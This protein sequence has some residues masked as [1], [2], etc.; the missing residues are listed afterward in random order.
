MSFEIA[1][2]FV[3]VVPKIDSGE[4]DAATKQVEGDFGGTADNI[5]KKGGKLGGALTKGV[6]APIVGV[7]GALGGMAMSAADSADGIAKA[8][9][10]AGVST[11]SYQEL[12]YALG[13]AGVEQGTFDRLLQRNNQ[14]LGR[15]AEGNEKYASAYEDLGI[16]ITDSNGEL[17]SSEDVF[18][19]VMTALAGIEDPAIR[20]AKA[21]ELLG[22]KSG[23]ELA[24][25]LDGGIDGINGARDA[26]HDLGIVMDKDAMGAA[27]GF[28]DSID[29]LK[30]AFGGIVA[31]IGSAALPMLESLM[32]VIQE[33]LVPAIRSFAEMVGGLVEKFVNASP[34]M[35]GFIAGAIGIAAAAG[36][37]I[38][39][40]SKVIGVFGKL[41]KAFAVVKKAF[42][43]MKVLMLAN[44]FV[45]IVAA[46]VALVVLIVMN[47]DTIKEYLAAAWEWIKTTAE[48]V[49]N[50]ISEF[51]TN[52]WNGLVEFFVSIWEGIKEFFTEAW[53]G[54]KALATTVWDGIKTYFET[55]FN[56]YKTIIE[57]A[58][59]AITQFLSNIWT[60]IK[61]KAESIWNAVK[62]FFTTVF[63]AYRTIIENAWN[64]I[65]DFLSGLWNGIKNTAAT[66]FNAVKD[67]FSR[68][69]DGVKTIWN[70]LKTFFTNLWGGI[71][72]TAQ[73][74]FN[75][76]KDKVVN[77]FSSMK[78][79]VVGVW[80]TMTSRIRGFVNRII[81]F[82]NKI[83]RSWNGISLSMPSRSFDWNGPLPGGDVT[84]GGFSIGTP[85][86]P[87]IPLLAKGGDILRAGSAIVGE[88]GPELLDL[89]RGARVSPLDGKRGVHIE[90]L[91]LAVDGTF[92]FTN[93]SWK[94]KFVIDMRDALV[95]LERED[96]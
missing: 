25:A 44:P 18:D 57:T 59:N 16:A 70:N 66:I 40:V 24:M 73:R 82:I 15:A 47:W 22:T 32:P 52:L 13:Q 81:G 96:A 74:I 33:N 94:R 54:I 86:L 83:I 37:V 87:T 67:F 71:R 17:R 62:A 79:R 92:D 64:R 53:E 48:T 51:F 65:R 69:L 60:G 8:A 49:W 12:E 61:S 2:A 1:E 41:S 45:A 75:S 7:V 77:A 29:N 55:V 31:E 80:E 21:G 46:V 63:T 27:E 56:F 85:N 50:A 3:K 36:P 19:D 34:Q 11:D 43:A 93:P 20:A 88:A 23:R 9:R 91:V 39:I 30:R 26:A 28:N 42:L 35:Q 78:D 6:T 10:A 95:Q 5:S 14:R 84:V 4:L 89:P 72:D 90:Q 76:V 68:W 58:W 38:S